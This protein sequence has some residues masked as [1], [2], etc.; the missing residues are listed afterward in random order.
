MRVGQRLPSDGAPGLEPLPTGGQRADTG[1]GAVGDHQRLVHGEQGWQ[2]R[3]VGL[4]LLPCRP[5]SSVLV[6]RV[7]QFD[8][9]QGQT[10]DKQHDVRPAGVSVLSDGEL[11]DCQPVVVGG[12]VEVDD[13]RLR[14]TDAPLAVPVLHCHAIYE[15]PV[16]GTVAG[17]KGRAF[18]AGKLAEGVVQRRR[19]QAGVQLSE[20]VLHP[21]LQHHLPIVG[22]LGVGR[23]RSDVRAVGHLPAQGGRPVKGSLFNVGFGDGGHG[24]SLLFWYYRQVARVS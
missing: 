8:D 1:L 12:V 16:E 18:G 3:L 6:R 13:L 2:L 10:V 21:T 5:D 9:G 19:R 7:L 22:A 4:E 14:S 11:V 20:G 15:H 24:T 17:F 23:A